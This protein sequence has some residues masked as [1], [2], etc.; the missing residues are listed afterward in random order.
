MSCRTHLALLAQFLRVLVANLNRPLQK[1]LYGSGAGRCAQDPP[2]YEA[3]ED[4]E[5]GRAV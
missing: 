1:D 5:A 4:T 3:V 2:G